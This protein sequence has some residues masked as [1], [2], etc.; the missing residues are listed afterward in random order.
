MLRSVLAVLFGCSALNAQ[1][2]PK[3]EFE[4]A[5]VKASPPPEPGVAIRV[6]CRGGPGTND[7]VL[8][9]CQN[10]SLSNLVTLAY[11]IAFYQLS[12]PDWA[13]TTRFDL[14]A[15][16]PQGTT[17]E[18][19]ALMIQ[20]LLADRFKLAVHRES[21]EIQRYEL[22]VAKNGRK[23]KE[24]APPSPPP[25]NDSQPAPGPPKPDK[26]GYPA[27]GPRGGMAIMRNRAR[28]YQPETTMAALASQLSGQFGAPVAD[29]TG[30]T[31]KYEIGLYWIAAPPG[32]LVDS[33][34]DGPDLRQA[35]QEQLGLRVESKKGPV[36]FLVVDHVDRTPGEN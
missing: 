17:K 12:A 21:R 16:V 6:G 2:A 13:V 14:R 34:P 32:V 28:L 26:D 27:I 4:V 5:S 8:Y 15:S 24:A 35:L 25:S 18:Q 36:E 3:V 22:T 23:F 1:P 19:L 11:N 9:T 33:T 7:P 30:L 10:I 29:L 31:G 20:N